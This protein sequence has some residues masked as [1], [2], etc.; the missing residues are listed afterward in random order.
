MAD[1]NFGEPPMTQAEYEAEYDRLFGWRA[2]W[3]R[4]SSTLHKGERGGRLQTRQEAIER[5]AG[6]A[7]YRIGALLLAW[8]TQVGTGRVAGAEAR[9]GT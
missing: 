8:K 9:P 5:R 6:I 4:L 1:D 2:R 3:M 7:N